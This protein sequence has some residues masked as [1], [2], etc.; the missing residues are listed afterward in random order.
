MKPNNILK[1]VRQMQSQVMQVQERLAE[2][3]VEA[4]VGGGMVSA[5]FTGQGDLVSITIDPE[6]INKDEKEILEDLVVSA[7]NEGL[8]KSR[9]LMTERMGGITSALGAMGMGF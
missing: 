2:E 8:K 9:N 7:V 4:S 3:L 6:V 1:Q 5:V